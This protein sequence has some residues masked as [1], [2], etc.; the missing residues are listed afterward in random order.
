[1][2][3]ELAESSSA[4]HGLSYCDAAQSCCQHYSRV[5]Q[6]SMQNSTLTACSAQ[7]LV[8]SS[9]NP[10]TSHPAT[11]PGSFISVA[12]SKTFSALPGPQVLPHRGCRG[13][14]L[15]DPQPA[16]APRSILPGPAA[17]P[18]APH[19]HLPRARGTPM[20]IPPA[21]LRT[22][23]DPEVCPSLAMLQPLVYLITRLH[24]PGVWH[25]RLT[26]TSTQKTYLIS[27]P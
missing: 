18:H 17:A 13:A 23:H 10:Q 24:E 16:G 8:G 25:R 12:Q 5:L 3:L 15:H 21:Q 1:M 7:T 22:H 20:L 11:C 6:I 19:H 27:R 14:G 26:S 2:G 4:A 9:A